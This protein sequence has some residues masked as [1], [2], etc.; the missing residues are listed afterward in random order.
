MAYDVEVV[1]LIFDEMKT[2]CKK[3]LSALQNEFQGMRV[4]RANPHLLDKVLVDCWGT[5]TPIKH[6]ANIS[7]PEAK[8]LQ[9]SVFDPSQLKAAEKAIIAANLGIMPA[10]DGKVLRMVFPDVTEERRRAL[11][12]DIKTAAENGKVA[13][14]NIRRDAIESLRP[15]KKDGEITEDDLK[16]FEKDADKEASHFISEIDKVSAEKEKEVLSV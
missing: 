16:I 15:L 2:R 4:G 1:D 10:N 9:I 7:V 8:I 11:C 12:K 5:P 14:R 6:M 3:T 13:I